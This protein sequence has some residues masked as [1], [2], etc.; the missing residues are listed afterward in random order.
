MMRMSVA[1]KTASNAAV[2]LASRSRMRNRNRRRGVVEVHEQVAGLLGEPGAGGVGG[3]AEDVYAAG[4]V[5]DDEER[6][7]PVQG[8][9][10]EVEQVAGEDRVRLGLQELASRMVRL[11]AAR[12]RFRRCAGSSR[13]WRRRS[14]SRGRRVRRGCVGIPR[15]G[16]RWPGAGSGRAGR[17]GWLV[18]RVGSAGWSSGGRSSW[19]CQ[20]RMVAGV[21][22]SPRR[23]GPGSSRAEGGDQG[24][25]GPAHP[26]AWRAPSEHG[27]L[28]AQDQDLDVLGGVG[29]G[30]QHDPA[31]E[32]GEHQ[33]DQPQRHQGIMPG[34][35]Q[36]RSSRS[37]E[38]SG[39]S[40]T[41]PANHRVNRTATCTDI[42]AEQM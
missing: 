35:R 21:T 13:R 37:E 10:V 11:A 17:R 14:G 36:R 6:V 41:H 8:D 39:V 28:V 9:G 1:V 4:G 42:S 26:R 15:W 23:R 3:D 33:V 24:A 18:G 31:Q 7:E 27:E 40:G 19:R 34:L 12:G 32:L 22:S 2:N 29:S 16:S 5:L 20:R 38:V 25:V 30:A